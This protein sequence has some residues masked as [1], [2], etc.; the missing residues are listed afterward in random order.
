MV[1][2]G[3]VVVVVLGVLVVVVNDLVVVTGDLVVVVGV[4]RVVV[5]VAVAPDEVPVPLNSDGNP[6]F[7]DQTIWKPTMLGS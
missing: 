4:L 7:D 5:G 1:V 2:G 3:L 6:I